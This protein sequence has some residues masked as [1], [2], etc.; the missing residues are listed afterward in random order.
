MMMQRDMGRRRFLQLGSGIGLSAVVGTGLVAC[1]G[2]SGSDDAGSA[3]GGPGGNGQTPDGGGRVV[4]PTYQRF[5]G[6]E[7]D[8]PG[9]E[10]GVPDAYF[11]YPRPANPS[12]DGPPGSGGVVRAMFGITT[13]VPPAMGRNA[14]WQGLNERL[15]VELQLNMMPMSDYPT[16]FQ[17]SI[18]GGDLP[19]LVQVAPTTPRLPDMLEATFTDLTEYLSGDAVLEYPNL[20]NLH[21]YAWEHC[22]YNNGIYAVPMLNLRAPNNMHVRQDIVDAKALNGDPADAEEFFELCQ[23]LTDDRANTYA[24]AQPTAILNNFITRMFEAPVG[25]SADGGAFV[26]AWETEEFKAAL[27]YTARLWEA[28]IFHPD[29]FAGANHSQL[30]RSGGVAMMAE[31]GL[32]YRSVLADEV[33]GLDLTFMA[34]PLADGGGY[35]PVVHG[36]G[37]YRLTA[38]KQGLD[39]DRTRELLRILNWLAA[40]FGTEE[41]LYLNFGVEDEHHTWDDNQGVPDPTDK[42]GTERTPVDLVVRPPVPVFDPAYPQVAERFYHHQ[43]QV[44]PNGISNPTAGLYSETE[45]RSGQAFNAP[46]SDAINEIIQGRRP[47]TDWDQVIDTWRNSGGDDARGEYEVAFEERVNS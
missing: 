19:D 7:P 42:L 30:F 14:H 24:L 9:D 23:G 36:T 29:S 22:I 31:G 1:G 46:V 15:G 45:D 28:G 12:T 4:L 43:K 35:A 37:V 44:V 6:I 34:P 3:T 18:A 17:S 11:S 41:Y 8:L 5:D 13:T 10:H 47:I 33:P 26:N 38:I 21:P 20:A 2:D 27:E 39:E 40:P 32:H 16:T 25:W